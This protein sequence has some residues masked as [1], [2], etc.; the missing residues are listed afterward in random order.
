MTIIWFNTNVGPCLIWDAL[1]SS[2]K[3]VEQHCVQFFHSWVQRSTFFIVAR[4]ACM[5]ACAFLRVIIINTY[6]SFTQTQLLNNVSFI[7]SFGC[8]RKKNLML[9][10][11]EPCSI[12]LLFTSWHTPYQSYLIS[13]CNIYLELLPPHYRTPASMESHHGINSTEQ[14]AGASRQQ[15]WPM[16]WGTPFPN[17]TSAFAHPQHR[18]F[19]VNI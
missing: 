2:S 13:A 6:L 12:A 9:C 1:T 14:P 4:C 11:Q 15:I 7:T 8:S 17:T 18:L 3:V 10:S 19:A 5:C 16:N